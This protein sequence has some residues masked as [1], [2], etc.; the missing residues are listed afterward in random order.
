[1]AEKEFTE[2]SKLPQAR[3]N[4]AVES[5]EDSRFRECK[6]PAKHE[7]SVGV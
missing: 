7:S 2:Q 5:T 6:T 4:A 3:Q 1:M